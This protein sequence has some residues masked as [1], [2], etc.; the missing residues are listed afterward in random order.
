MWKKNSKTEVIIEISNIKTGY[1]LRKLHTQ[2]YLKKKEK[3]RVSNIKHSNFESLKFWRGNNSGFG[4]K[5]FA[6]RETKYDS[7][8]FQYDSWLFS[9]KQEL[10]YSVLQEINMK[11]IKIK[12]YESY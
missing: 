4:K 5:K 10:K 11:Y 8:Y 3:I 12:N 6:G 7:Y 2:K 1:I 9:I